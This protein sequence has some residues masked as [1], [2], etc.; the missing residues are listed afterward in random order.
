M[1]RNRLHPGRKLKGT[2]DPEKRAAK[3]RAQKAAGYKRKAGKGATKQMSRAQDSKSR[4][5][6]AHGARKLGREH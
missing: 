1:S 2:R 5:K 3:R 6:A 4:K